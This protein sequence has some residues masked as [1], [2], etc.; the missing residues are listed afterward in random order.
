MVHHE[1]MKCRK[2]RG[3]GSS[4][5]LRFQSFT[6]GQALVGAS[7]SLFGLIGFGLS[8]NHF[9]GGRQAR[10]MRGFYLQWA[11]YGILFGVLAGSS[12]RIAN[13]AHIGGLIGGLVLGFLVERDLRRPDRFAGLWNVLTLVCWGATL[14]ALGM[15]LWKAFG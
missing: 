8:Y 1:P 11:L 9:E 14:T 4:F 12:L 7:G 13:S 5:T 6:G 2:N 3:K 15:M 10:A